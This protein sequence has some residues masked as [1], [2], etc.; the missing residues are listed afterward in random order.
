VAETAHAPRRTDAPDLDP[1]RRIRQ[2][3]AC[4]R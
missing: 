2:A 3:A 4:L 1:V